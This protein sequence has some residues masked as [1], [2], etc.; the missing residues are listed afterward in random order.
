[1]SGTS[2]PRLAPVPR[3][4]WGE[5]VVDALR[6]GF[7]DDVARRFAAT[8]ENAVPV[9][10]VLGTLLHH[11]ALAGPFLAYNNVLLQNPTLEPRHREL[12]VL[13]VAWRTRCRYELV[14]HARLAPR[15]GITAE[16]ITAIAGGPPVEWTPLET[17]LLDATDQLV[18]G[19]RVD[20][21]TWKRLA[22][23]LDERRLVE[24][25]FV[26]GTYVGLAM[27]FNSFGLQVDPDLQEFNR[28]LPEFEE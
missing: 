21:D 9:P 10:N 26:V 12:M 3:E 4:T 2:T 15:L 11:P 14:Q 23:Q 20:D 25:V 22:E 8:G 17:A 24:L 7:S 18:D 27:A 1:V 16:E 5:D 19:Y 13:R 28:T 6:L